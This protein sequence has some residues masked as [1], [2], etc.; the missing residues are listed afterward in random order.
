[1]Y[2]DEKC[3]LCN[4]DEECECIDFRLTNDELKIIA[5]CL[6]N[7]ANKSEKKSFLLDRIYKYLCE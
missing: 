3:E 1:M 4:E 5:N 2:D 7:C 6:L